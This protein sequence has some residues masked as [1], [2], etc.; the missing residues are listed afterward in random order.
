MLYERVPM[1]DGNH[2][3]REELVITKRETL[4][5]SVLK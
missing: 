2:R 4:L 3:Q 1:H 5:S